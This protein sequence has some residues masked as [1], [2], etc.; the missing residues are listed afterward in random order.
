MNQKKIPNFLIIGAPKCGT[1]AL[2][3]FLSQH[4][5][6]FIS[7]HKEPRF[8]TALP[9]SMEKEITGSGP[10]L[11]GN[12]KKGWSWYASLFEEASEN[13]IIGEASTV[14]FANEDAASLIKKHCPDIKIILM[15]RNPVARIYS[16]YWQEHKLGFD[17]PE[18]ESMLQSNH[19]RLQYF[20]HISH[21]KIHIERYLKYFSKDQIH[22]IIQEAF[23]LDPEFHFN[24][25]IKFLELPV[26]PINVWERKNE[27]SAP[28]SKKMALL[29]QKLRLVD[30]EKY[31]PE[32][33][34]KKI[35]EKGIKFIRANQKPHK[36]PPLNPDVFHQL[37]KD[38]EED[39]CCVESKLN[40]QLKIWRMP[41]IQ[42]ANIEE[43]K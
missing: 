22:I 8:F 43:G 24:Q 13:Q 23:K 37:C 35:K 18:F 39:I 40:T 38:Y 12:Y 4:P 2:A 1:T 19:P 34:S 36:Y 3:Y 31:M 20:Q 5:C 15:L 9:G 11:S 17:F 29:L 41:A 7:K 32:V 42:K 30:Y 6:I 28:K 27:M 10:R 16:H 21:Y 26:H 33:L 14:Y 25:L